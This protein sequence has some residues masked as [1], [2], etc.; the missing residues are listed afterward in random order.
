MIRYFKARILAILLPFV[1][2][3]KP[4]MHWVDEFTF[5][6]SLIKK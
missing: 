6:I 1:Y 3:V 5:T 2:V 4:S